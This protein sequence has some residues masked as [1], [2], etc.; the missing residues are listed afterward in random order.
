MGFF[1]RFRLRVIFQNMNNYIILFIGVIFAN[2]LLMF[3]LLF[4]AVLDHYQEEMENNL[5]CNY[6]YI[7][8]VPL[9]AMDE[10]HKLESLLAMMQFARD[11]ETENEEA[12]KFSAYSLNTL[13][14]VYKSESVML[15]GINKDSRYIPVDV[16][17]SQVYISSAYSE[18]FGIRPGDTIQLKEAYEDTLYEFTVTDIYDYEGGLAVFMNQAMLNETFDLD[19]DYFSGYLSNTEITDIDSKYIGSVIDLEA[20]TKISRQLDVSMGKHDAS[21]RWFCHYHFYGF[22]LSAVKDYY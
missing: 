8:Q 9:D 5:L 13:D 19:K 21:C 18:K 11:V 15:Y 14:G 22:N 6:Q 17:D 7:L 10:E 20:L 1:Q 16:S 2:L 4:P 3:G 12:E